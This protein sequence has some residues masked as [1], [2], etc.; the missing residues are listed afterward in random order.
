MSWRFLME[1]DPGACLPSR[2]DSKQNRVAIKKTCWENV[3]FQHF[4]RFIGGMQLLMRGHGVRKRASERISISG[5][6]A[7]AAVDPHRLAALAWAMVS[8]AREAPGRC[9]DLMASDS[10]CLYSRAAFVCS[11]MGRRWCRE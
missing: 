8:H 11:L 3:L 6:C 1:Y 4:S 5:A 7:A 9:C 2:I 10:I